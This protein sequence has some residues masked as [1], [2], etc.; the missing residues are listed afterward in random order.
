MNK[1]KDIKKVNGKN[2]KDNYTIT[3]KNLIKADLVEKVD[4][5]DE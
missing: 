5:K 2:K 1:E 4:D 3:F